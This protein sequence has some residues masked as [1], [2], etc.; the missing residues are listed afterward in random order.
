MDKL[1]K[2]GFIKI[3]LTIGATTIASALVSM[4]LLMGKVEKGVEAYN[5]TK[6]LEI[7][8]AIVN[9]KLDNIIDTQTKMMTKLD[10]H[11]DK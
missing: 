6:K 5:C 11:I 3:G 8:M 9:T 7:Q 10:K 2:M 4:G 1:A